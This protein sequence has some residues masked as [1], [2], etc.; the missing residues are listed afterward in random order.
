MI[1]IKGLKRIEE[2]TIPIKVD[3]VDLQS[4]TDD[5]KE[6][7]LKEGVLWTP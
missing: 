1:T 2:T 3:L 7:V 4:V 6:Q 5:F